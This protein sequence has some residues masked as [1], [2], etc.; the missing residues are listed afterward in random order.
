ML[1]GYSKAV[2]QRLVGY[3]AGFK[4]GILLDYLSRVAGVR[5]IPLLDLLKISIPV[6]SSSSLMDAESEGWEIKSFAAAVFMDLSS[7]SAMAYLNWF[8]EINFSSSGVS[9]FN[10]NI[11][12]R[13]EEKSHKQGFT[14]S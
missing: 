3:V 6:S 12:A 9:P 14:W 2:L 11:I 4:Q 13:G 1:G 8:N 10:L 7:E 5:V